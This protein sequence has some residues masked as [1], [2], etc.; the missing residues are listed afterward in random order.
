MAGFTIRSATAGDAQVC[1]DIYRPY[2]EDST[3]SF[4]VEL[5]GTE[6]MASRITTATATH[7]WLILEENGR[8]IGYA[9]A[10]PWDSREAYEWSCETSVYLNPSSH[11][12]G[13]GRAVYEQLLSRLAQRGYRMAVGRIAIPNERSVRLHERLGF[14]HVGTLRSIGWKHGSWHDVA[15]MQRALGDAHAPPN[16]ISIPCTN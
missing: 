10:K 4:E 12:R 5:P 11:G 13:G 16:E 6:E 14:D 15:M 8:A 7:E 9:S 3:A 2:V 1:R